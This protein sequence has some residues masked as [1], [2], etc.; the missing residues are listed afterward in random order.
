M[1]VVSR[2]WPE[3]D[4]SQDMSHRT[5]QDREKDIFMSF[6]VVAAFTW[7]MPRCANLNPWLVALCLPQ[8]VSSV[9]GRCRPP[10]TTRTGE[11]SSRCAKRQALPSQAAHTTP[12]ALRPVAMFRATRGQAAC[13]FFS[14]CLSPSCQSRCSGCFHRSCS[15][16][17]F[18]R[19]AH[20]H[21]STPKL[22]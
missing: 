10:F 12:G 13:P 20:L 4:P 18:Q 8:G 11:V 3:L 5:D 16:A 1:L 14:G 19:E 15:E 6:A 7:T 22:V 21:R 2:Q 17:A 9:V